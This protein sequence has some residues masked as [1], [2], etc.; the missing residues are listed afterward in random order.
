MWP[1]GRCP[2]ARAGSDTLDFVVSRG[3]PTESDADGNSDKKAARGR[4]ARGG[5]RSPEDVDLAVEA[6]GKP[7]FRAILA[8]LDAAL[9][10]VVALE[11]SSD[12][13]FGRDA[14]GFTVTPSGARRGPRHGGR[15]SRA[16]ARDRP[17][18]GRRSRG[19]GRRRRARG[20]DAGDGTI[21]SEVTS[22]RDAA[23]RIAAAAKFLRRRTRPVRRPICCCAGSGGASCA[24]RLVTSIRA[25][26]KPRPPRPARDSRGCCSTRAGRSCSSRAKRSWPRR[27]V[28][29]G[30]TCS[31]TRS[32]PVP[33]SATATTAWPP[34][35][36]VN[37][38][39][40]SL[41]FRSCHT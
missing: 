29:A 10:A 6:S 37:C 24:P 32:P 9:A 39:H 13:R 18:S 11:T 36:A 22:A 21:S 41:P 40:C 1:C 12:A 3:I 35:C 31:A 34:S 17:G 4:G 7:F 30:S 25:C 27:R 19:R 5:K 14:P 20:G 16:S 8:D 28:A 15:H 2:I 23:A 33:T 26:S 38:A